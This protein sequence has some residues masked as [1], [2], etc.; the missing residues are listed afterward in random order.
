MS[1]IFSF[2]RALLLA[3]L[4][5]P[6]V[7]FAGDGPMLWYDAPAADWETQALPIGN[8]AL[9][10]MVFGDPVH[11]HLQFNEKTLWTGGPGAPGY[12]YGNWESPRPNAIDEVRR[13]IAARGKADPEWVASLLKTGQVSFGAYQ[14]FGDLYLDFDGIDAEPADYRRTLDI[15]E[16][17][18]GV[19]F[20][21]G[22]TRHR[23]EYFASHPGHVI[24]ARFS[25]DRPGQV[26]FALRYASPRQDYRASA[27]GDRLTIRGKLADNGLVFEAQVRVIARGGAVTGKDGLLRV[28]GADSVVVLLSAG[29]D[30]ALKYP[31]YR[32][33]D[34]HARITADID[35][36]AAKGF[37]ALRAAHVADYRNLF[38]RVSLQLGQRM[39]DKPTDALLKAYPSGDAGADR[40][41][42]A[43]YFQ[44]GRYLLISASRAGSLPA[45]LQGVWNHSVKPPWDSDYHVNINL[46]MNYW[47]AETTNLA[48]TAEPFVRYVEAMRAPGEVTAREMFGAPGWVQQTITNPWGYTGVIDWATAF[49]FP[50]AGAWLMNQVVDQQRFAPDAGFL[51]DSLYPRLKGASEFWLATLQ[52]D[53]RDGTL[54]ATPSFSPEHGNYTAGAAMSQQIVAELFANTLQAANALHVDRAFR[55]RLQAAMAKLDPGLRIGRWGQ[56]QEWKEDVDDPQDDHRHVSHLYALHPGARIRPLRDT[57]LADAARMTL[58]GR[59]DA[60]T[61]WSK[62]WKSNFWARLRDGDHAFKML[63][64][65]LVHSTLPNLFDTHPPFQID[66]NFGATAGVAEM[67]LQSQAGEIDILPALPAAWADGAVRGLRARGD[68]TVDIRWRHGRT[69]EIVLHAG[70]KGPLAVRSTLFEDGTVE[71]RDAA[72]G[73]PVAVRRDGASIAFEARAGHEYRAAARN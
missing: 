50:E 65:Q 48:E 44:F 41:L 55:E 42:E 64:E 22:G 46:Q 34:P 25:A 26:S 4:F 45:N 24:A 28:R 1:S 15:G 59:G 38:D 32:G 73:R 52:V 3:A 69:E 37:D 70:R 68:V 67:L 35:R 19:R 23:R 14:T 51:R 66:G 47:P 53:P 10:A 27:D 30:Y 9:G 29:T 5:L 36:A 20:R 61:G 57:A 49:W 71:L 72:S 21:S 8:G 17:V 54:V 62:A 12:T 58:K 31:D 11:E 43:L 56:L 33:E 63:G 13:E 7:S 60:G 39:P 6:G 2:A 18:A 40:A 16:A